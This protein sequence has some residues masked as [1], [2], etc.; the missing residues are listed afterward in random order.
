MIKAI[1]EIEILQQEAITTAEEGY[2]RGYDQGYYQAI[3]DIKH[4]FSTEQCEKFESK[5]YEWR[6]ANL[7]KKSA[8]PLIES[9]NVSERKT[10]HEW[11]QRLLEQAVKNN[12]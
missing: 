10:K 9:S 6:T 1:S 7:T 12:E 4:G 5:L 8:P 2:R 11:S 3:I